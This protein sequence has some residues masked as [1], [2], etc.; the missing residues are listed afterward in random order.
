MKKK[1]ATKK[2]GLTKRQ[3]DTM[4]KHAKHH[5]KSHMASMRKSML[6]GKTF[7]EAHR[8]AMKKAGK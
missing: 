2:T 1:K 6:A 4:K 7:S 5:S 8:V 3:E